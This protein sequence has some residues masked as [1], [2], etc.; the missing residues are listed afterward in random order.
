MPTIPSPSPEQKRL[1]IER[2]KNIDERDQRTANVLKQYEKHGEDRRAA[3]QSI[4]PFDPPVR[5]IILPPQTIG[6]PQS[7]CLLNYLLMI[8]FLFFFK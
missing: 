6:Q 1:L 4:N 7:R 8:S 5:T 2:K 3:T